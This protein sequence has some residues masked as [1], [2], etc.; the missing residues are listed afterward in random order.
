VQRHPV[1]GK[2]AAGPAIG[3]GILGNISDRIGRNGKDPS[4]S[5]ESA[6]G[7]QQ[8]LPN[9]DAAIESLEKRQ[10]MRI[11][12]GRSRAGLMQGKIQAPRKT[13]ATRQHQGR[14]PLAAARHF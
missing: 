14:E 9:L 1:I 5:R 12:R 8:E 10:R 2:F 6:L 3:Y 4:G 7:L 11:R 13:Q